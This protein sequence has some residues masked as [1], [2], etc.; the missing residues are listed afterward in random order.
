MKR[1]FPALAF[2][3]LA[4]GCVTR[5]GSAF[6]GEYYSPQ[7]CSLGSEFDLSLH[8]D[9]SYRMTQT[10]AEGV[11]PEMPHGDRAGFEDRGRWT[12]DGTAIVLRSDEGKKRKLSAEYRDG[13]LI[14]ADAGRIG[15]RLEKQKP[16]Q[17]PEPTPTAG[18]SAA[19]QPLVPAAVVAHL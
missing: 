3:L 16:N 4:F 13:R 19:E 15:L 11:G 12:F 8:A 18:T 9:G 5:D 2:A 6:V 17:S 1:A 7:P 10:L 14:L